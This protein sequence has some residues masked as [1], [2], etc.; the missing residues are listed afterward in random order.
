[1]KN[2]W[3]VTIVFRELPDDAD[4]ESVKILTQAL[5]DSN[6]EVP[7]EIVGILKNEVKQ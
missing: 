3:I 6:G 5:L 4:N 1:M 2:D 7:Y